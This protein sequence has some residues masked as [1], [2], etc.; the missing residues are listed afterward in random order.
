MAKLRVIQFGL[1]PIGAGVARVIAQRPEFQFVGAIDIDPAKVGKD[2]GEL[3]G[4][5][6]KL[7]VPVSDDAAKVL[8]Q[9]ADVVMHCTVS[10]LAKAEPQLAMII[11][12]GKNI[13]STCEELAMPWNKKAI[14]KRIDALAQKHKV[15][16]LGTGIN[17]GFMMDTVPIVLT[18]VC[19]TVKRVRVKRV[20]DASKR[21]RPLQAKIGTGLTVKEFNA[22]AGKE[23]RHVGL[24][25]S[26]MLIARAL[27]WKLDKIE[28]TIAPVVAQKPIKTEY[29]D[30]R[31]GL[32]TGVEQSGFGYAKGD[33]VIEL[34]L[35]MCVDAGEGV[36]EVW[37]EGEPSIHSIIQG[38]H[39]DLSTAAV[40]VN[41]VRRVVAANPGLVTMIDLPII[42]AG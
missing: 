7:G 33:Q 21:R 34:H 16:V 3:I 1:G 14:A 22:K 19:Q 5:H 6:R 41:C 25:E 40:A 28:E 42:S 4:I 11:K 26:V 17:P 38:V 35:R 23:I 12:A 9:K 36:D 37:L 20:V 15:T 32:V 29:F 31:P 30:V 24:T 27:H 18:G 10:S 13:V 2:L 8:K 39:G